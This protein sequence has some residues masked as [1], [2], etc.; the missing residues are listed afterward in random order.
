MTA[1]VRASPDHVPFG[2]CRVWSRQGREATPLDCTGLL[3]VDRY[4][5]LAEG[6]LRALFVYSYAL[7]ALVFIYSDAVASERLGGRTPI[8]TACLSAL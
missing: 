3:L 7:N 1:N 2:V 4:N 8:H 5:D 6:D